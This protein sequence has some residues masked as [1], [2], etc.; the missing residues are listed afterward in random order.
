MPQHSTSAPFCSVIINNYNYD[1]F[2]ASAIE[3]ALNQDFPP[4]EREVIVV[5]DGSTDRS[6]D[7]IRKFGD[8]VIPVFR[9]NGGQGSAINAGCSIARGEVIAFLD[10]DDYW[11]GRKLANVSEAFNRRAEVDFVY[12]SMEVLGTSG[13]SVDRYIFPEPPERQNGIPVFLPGYLGGWLPHFSPTSGMAIRKN[14]LDRALP[15]PGE[16]RIAADIY[17]HYILPFYVREAEFLSAPLGFYRLHGENLSGGN[18]P[19][20]G[21]LDQ[22]ISTLGK[23]GRHITLHGRSLGLDCS[24]ILARLDA[25]R[26]QYEIIRMA[27]G[28]QR[29]RAAWRALFFDE[30]LPGDGILLKTLRKASLFVTACISPD[31]HLWFQ[32]LH[33]KYLKMRGDRKEKNDRKLLPEGSIRSAK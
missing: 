21:K 3:S 29:C 11:D 17:F 33:R 28:G 25:A 2:V 30:F 7:K 20:P 18:A 8:S 27:S 23:L 31:Q 6:R 15:V 22:D 12:H 32:R 13:E 26:L 24:A 9:E 4:G 10:S 5:D 19:N 1:R 16:F 14:C